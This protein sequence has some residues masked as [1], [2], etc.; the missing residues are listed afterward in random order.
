MFQV[1]NIYVF[2]WA[3]PQRL[4][5]MTFVGKDTLAVAHDIY[6]IFMN[7]R[8]NTEKVYVANS[9]ELGDGVD[10]VAGEILKMS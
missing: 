7:L 10:V 1:L 9:K 2:R 4:D 5:Q 8:S 3:I 6:I